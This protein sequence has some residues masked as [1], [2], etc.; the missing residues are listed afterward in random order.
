MQFKIFR[1]VVEFVTIMVMDDFAR[2]KHATEHLFDNY[3]TAFMPTDLRW[4]AIRYLEIAVAPPDTFGSERHGSWTQEAHKTTK[5]VWTEAATSGAAFRVKPPA[6]TDDLLDA[7]GWRNGLATQIARLG[8][9]GFHDLN[10]ALFA[11]GVYRA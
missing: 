3:M 11:Q 5:H 10:M 8:I 1:S 4:P 7:Q 9:G 6:M 2:L